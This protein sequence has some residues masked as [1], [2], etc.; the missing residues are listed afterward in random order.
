M[1]L[2]RKEQL[3]VATRT[4]YDL[5][6]IGA[7]ASGAGVALDASLRG[8]QVLLID[9]GDFGGATSSKSTKLIHGG[10]RYLEQAFTK[11]DFGQLK[12]VYH[13][14]HERHTL[15]HLAP[16]LTRSIALITPV[17]RWLA[18]LYYTIGLRMYGWF[19]SGQDRLPHSRWLS[20]KQALKH[21]PGLARWV[22]SAVMYYDGQLDDARYA[23]SLVLTSV[24]AGATV[25]NHTSLVDFDRLE[26]GRIHGATLRDEIG[27]KTFTVKARH[28]VNCTG[29]Y[30]DAI[31]Q[32]A[33]PRMESRIRPSKGIHVML[34][35]ILLNSLDGLLI[36]ETKDGRVVFAL[37]FAGRTL[38]GTTDTPYSDLDLEPAVL[39]EEV[40]YLVQTLNPY[41]EVPIHP[42][43]VKAGFSGIRPLITTAEKE[44]TKSL[45]RDHEVEYDDQ[46]G[47]ISLL[48]GKWTT[49]RLMAS[50]TV[51][52]I[53]ELDE[54][55]EPDRTANHPLVGATGWH[56]NYEDDL[57][58]LYAISSDWAHHLS[59]HYG[60]DSPEIIHIYQE[61]P[62]HQEKW[63]PD[64]PYRV[65]EIIYHVRFEMAITIRD[66]L[67]QRT[68]LEIQDWQA[69][70]TVAP[71]IGHW[72]GKLF[73]WP[74][75]ERDA[76]ILSYRTYLANAGEKAGI[77]VK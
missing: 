72:L 37:P 2:E 55:E 49:Y 59:H 34:E 28:F 75:H 54:R 62:D 65:A 36:P 71:K 5:C 77:V 31:R 12:Q 19:A 33:N 42:D 22:H 61:H 70:Y 57:V 64:F 40:E 38:L 73:D 16:H 50:D 32:L 7:G 3:A 17:R 24:K 21:I 35:A 66:V 18:G 15:L 10:V 11:L 29:P 26:T 51:E 6:I 67:A 76:A 44:G 56:A 23:L 41:L 63:H 47:L 8:Y 53:L 25:I 48:G 1:V 9:R 46:S 52:R 30:S 58:R 27:Q 20:R 14:L 69:A 60:T 13:G 4:E 39:R 68:R 43:Q 45:L 74:E